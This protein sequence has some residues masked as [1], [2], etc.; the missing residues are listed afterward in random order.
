MAEATQNGLNLTT[1]AGLKFPCP[2][3]FSGKDE[4]WDVFQYKFRSYL[5]L[6][7]P[8]FKQLFVTASQQT[9]AI[10]LDLELDEIEILAAQV[11]NA[12]IA[13]C[14]GPAAK[15]VQRQENS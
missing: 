6:A 3:P 7:N 14:D 12:L 5:S 11:Q 13:L 1:S 15:I 10:E 9:S 2:K 4:D 8:K